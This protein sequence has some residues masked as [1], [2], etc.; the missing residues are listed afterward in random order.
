MVC[1]WVA[2]GGPGEKHDALAVK[3]AL[4][5]FGVDVNATKSNDDGCTALWYQCDWGRSRNVK[6]LLADPRVDVNLADKEGFTPLHAATMNGN[7]RCVEALLADD[8]VDVMSASFHGVTPLIFACTQLAG[9]VDQV[10]APGGN[11]P[12]RVLVLMLKSRRITPQCLAESIAFLRLRMPTPRMIHNAEVGGE[13]L[14]DIHK[15]ARLVLPV[16]VLR[17]GPR[18][19]SMVCPLPRSHPRPGPRPLWG[20]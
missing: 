10:G 3:Q 5:A 15:M 7:A 18:P 20:V 2:L 11:N 13:P 17:P 16:L 1:S 9:S 4:A 8:R 14:T 6:L 19:L 12:A